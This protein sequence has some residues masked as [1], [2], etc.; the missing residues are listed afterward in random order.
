MWTNYHTHSNY[1]D[2]KEPLSAYVNPAVQSLGFSSHAPL[3]FDCPWSM[4][5]SRLDAYLAEIAVMKQ[6]SPI[7]IYAGLEVD[8]IP[9][10]ISPKDFN[11]IDYSIGSIH[12]VDQ[13][14]NTHWEID[15][16]HTVFTVG[17]EKIFKNNYRAAWCRYFELTRQLLVESEPDILGHLDKMKIQNLE[18]KYFHE[19]E[20]WYQQEIRSLL[21][22]V[23]QTN[24]II[25]INTR[26]IYQQ[27]S[28]TTYPSP[29]IL[30][31]MKTLNI[32]VTISSDAHHSKDLCNQFE[33]AAS[34]LLKAG[35]KKIT[36]LK[37]GVWKEVNF[38]QNGIGNS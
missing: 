24:T 19:N 37:D 7:E 8:F 10:L 5:P 22:V 17:L 25:E 21:K 38:N 14:E 3:P 4:P 26:G 23:S 20:S 6:T 12:F 9:G 2:G 30:E 34:L 29:W 27:K 33:L 18:N 11:Q 13:Y 15:G 28:E 31:L 32:R 35:Y 36:I 16:L 1:C